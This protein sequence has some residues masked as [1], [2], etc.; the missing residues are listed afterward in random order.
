MKKKVFTFSIGQDKYTK[1]ILET[2][3]LYLFFKFEKRRLFL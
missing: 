2:A 3:F 1:S